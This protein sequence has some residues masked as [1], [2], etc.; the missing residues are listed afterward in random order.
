MDDYCSACKLEFRTEDIVVSCDGQCE[1]RRSFHAKCMGLSYDEGCACLHPSIFWMCDSCRDYIA[2]GRFRKTATDKNSNEYAAKSDFDILKTEVKLMSET[3]SKVEKK[4]TAEPRTS[5]RHHENLP[6][7][8]NQSIPLASS[9]VYVSEMTANSCTDPINLYVTNIATDVTE[10]E[11]KLMV[12]ESIGAEE[13]LSVKRLVPPWKNVSML[14][15]VSYK[16]SVEAK[17]RNSALKRS[18]WP[19]EVWCREFRDYSNI[20]WRPSHR[21]F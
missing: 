6:C 16:V 11:L 10:D 4:L 3:L 7:P 18:N 20:A 1:D 17:F 13:V 15:Y 14:D 8:D 2:K 9:S 19:R 21:T 12:C 5:I